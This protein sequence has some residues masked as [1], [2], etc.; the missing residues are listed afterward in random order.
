MELLHRVNHE[1]KSIKLPTNKRLS[2]HIL[3]YSHWYDQSTIEK[4]KA[5]LK[6]LL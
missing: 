3:T 4:A 2:R 1:D 5:D 6:Q